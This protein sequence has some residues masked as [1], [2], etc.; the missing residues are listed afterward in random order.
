MSTALVA[1]PTRRKLRPLQI[2]GYIAS[3][4]IVVGIFVFAIPKFA[5]YGAVWK[6]I[7]TLTPLEMGSLFAAMIFNLF[8][9]WWANMAALQGL[10]LWRAAVLTQTTTSIA[11]TL[12]AGGAIA[13]GLTYTILKSWGYTGERGALYVGA[14]GLWNIFT[15]LALPVLSLPI[16]VLTGSVGC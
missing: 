11:N 12:P 7:T 2:V 1:A 14:T 16:L 3:V 13:V 8:T 9:Y 15:K 6:A 4:L 10:T 5:D